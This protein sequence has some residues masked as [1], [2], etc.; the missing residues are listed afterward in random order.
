MSTARTPLE[1][2]MS[3][4]GLRIVLFREGRSGPPAQASRPVFPI[5][6]CLG[7]SKLFEQE[8][9]ILCRHPTI[10]LSHVR[11]CHKPSRG[12]EVRT[13]NFVV[14]FAIYRS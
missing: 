10:L 2:R 8:Y 1:T 14:Q 3:F 9:Y 5:D 11:G 13:R 12:R 6:E 7:Y 4:K